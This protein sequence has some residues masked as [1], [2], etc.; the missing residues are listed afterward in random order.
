MRQIRFFAYMVYSFSPILH[1][2]PIRYFCL[3]QGLVD[4]LLIGEFAQLLLIDDADSIVF[5]ILLTALTEFAYLTNLQKIVNGIY[6]EII[7][8][9]EKKRK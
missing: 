7:D 2:T 8:K 5:G 6:V 3:W 1:N 4:P 9:E